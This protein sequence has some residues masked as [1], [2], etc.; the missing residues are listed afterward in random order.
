MS[1]QH[2]ILQ[3]N[4]Q[5]SLHILIFDVTNIKTIDISTNI[6]I[7]LFYSPDPPVSRELVQTPA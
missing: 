3:K 1:N 2:S 6:E 5:F 4:H 7:S